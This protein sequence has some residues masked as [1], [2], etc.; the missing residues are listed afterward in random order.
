MHQFEMKNAALN[1]QLVLLSLLF[2]VC[3][4]AFGQNGPGKTWKAISGKSSMPESGFQ[5]SIPALEKGAAF[6]LDMAAMKALGKTA[7]K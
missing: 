6:E 5:P 7:K 3:T 1:F 2:F 4:Q